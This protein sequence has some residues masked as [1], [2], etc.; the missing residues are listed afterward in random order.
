M[1][2]I[3]GGG[4]AD[5]ISVK[6]A[7]VTIS[8]FTVKNASSHGIEYYNNAS[9][10]ITQNRLTGNVQGIHV[11]GSS[12]TIVHNTIDNN[13]AEGIWL[14]NSSN[15]VIYNNIIHDNDV[16][17]AGI[18]LTTCSNNEMINNDIYNEA[19]GILLYDSTDNTISNNSIH[20]NGHG[21]WIAG[22]SLN[23]TILKNDIR[24]NTASADS[25]IHIALGSDPSGTEIHYNTILDNTRY[26]SSYVVSFGV[27]NNT[28]HTVDATMNWWGDNSGPY[29]PFPGAPDYNPTGEGDAVS[30]YVIYR[31]WITRAAITPVVA[32]MPV[33]NYHLAQVTACQE[34]IEK[35]LPDDVPSGVQALLDT[36]QLHIDNANTTGNS[37]YANSELLKALEC[38]EEIQEKLGITCPH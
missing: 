18:F 6:D 31:P 34:C 30:D 32:F 14:I 37:I 19:F 5:V 33:K 7:T 27:F 23:N 10:T 13:T 24:N 17:H 11:S 38:C 3:N 8:G 2:T 28:A 25:G 15:C 26:D 35:N 1:T 21:I 22:T 29:D 20:D 9:G 4:G 12:V 16:V 36:M